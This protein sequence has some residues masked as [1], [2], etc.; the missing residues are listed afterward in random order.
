LLGALLL[1]TLAFSYLLFHRR[2]GERGGL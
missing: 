2:V 1:P